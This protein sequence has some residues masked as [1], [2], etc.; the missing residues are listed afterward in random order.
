[1]KRIFLILI[2][3]F[4]WSWSQTSSTQRNFG[5]TSAP[6]PSVSSMASYVNTPVSLST[7]V[8]DISLPLFSLPTGN[9]NLNLSVSLNYHVYNSGPNKRG[10]EV[11]IGWSMIKG[12]VISKE[13]VN[14]PDEKYQDASKYDYKKNKFDD[15][16]YYNF[17]GN[18]GKFKIVRD[19]INNTFTVNNISG[20]NLKIEYTRDSNPA[21]LILNS[22]TI[23]DTKGF[24]YVFSDY[25]IAR[26]DVRYSSGFN[27]RS[28]FYL[29]KIVDE[30]NTEIANFTYEKKSKYVGYQSLVL[31]YQYCKLETI[32]TRYGKITFENVFD[33]DVETFDKNEDPYK[34]KTI[35]QWNKSSHLISK[36]SFDYWNSNLKYLI[37]LDK[38]LKEIEKRTFDYSSES[39]NNYGPLS[40]PNKYGD[41]VCTDTRPINPKYFVSALKSMTLP[42]GG[43]VE[44][45][46]EAGEI[47][48]NKVNSQFSDD[49]IGEPNHQYLKVVDSINFDTHTTR[50]YT[51]QVPKKK[52]YRVIFNA[53]E[54]Y[55]IKNMHGDIIIPPTYELFNSAGQ[56][57]V[58]Y[59]KRCP[60]IEN[61]D[62]P[63]GTYTIKISGNGNGSLTNYAVFNTDG[64]IRNSYYVKIPRIKSI[65]YY[66]ANKI[67]KKT[68]TYN[69]DLFTDS[70][71]SSGKMF[72][73]ETCTHGE[74]IDYD[75][76]YIIYTNVKEIYGEPSSNLGYT[77]HYFKTLDDYI[78]N[79]QSWYRP[80]YNMVSSGVKMK[81]ET[82]NKQNQLLSDENMDYVFD[83]INGVNEYMVCPGYK[84]KASWLKSSKTVSNTYYS[85]GTKLQNISESTFNPSNFQL[86][87]MKE[88]APDGKITEKK[89]QY[90]GDLNNT[91]LINANMI[92]VPLQTNVKVNGILVGKTETKYDAASSLHP[93]SVTSFNTQNQNQVTEGYME[94]YDDK[95]NL[96]Q[97]RGKDNV[98][99][100]T[101][102][103]YYQTY[104]IAKIEG[105][106]FNQVS[107]LQSVI[108]AV[109]AS[110]ADADNPDNEA[111]LLQAL[112]NMRKDPALKDY[113]MTTST[114]DPMIGVTNSISPNG[115]KTTYVY[116]AFNRLIKI[117]DG[118]GKTVSEYQY[119]YRH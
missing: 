112:E 48:A 80:Y 69:Y 32:S 72:Y 100:T 86:S 1:M 25:S 109:S 22:F 14:D 90:A 21:T 7:G 10:T 54:T 106:S 44:Y 62:L 28:A 8:P 3:L 118:N 47:Y 20:N 107:V 9:Q 2:L 92:S 78:L 76:R 49:Y 24:K 97:A 27:Y 71:S 19:T 98:P 4:N 6:V 42:E 43:Q 105:L 115:M 53:D 96:L 102:W 94:Q 84:S 5:D 119:N 70:N 16:Y 58:E 67:V 73:N 114:Y 12:G 88:T 110:N 81:M 23:T 37:K 40:D 116:D 52:M 56:K 50:N 29:T 111:V 13:N 26:F 101:I 61:Y 39:L 36:Y 18:S 11:G 74:D 87:T 68:I 41:Y 82:F 51:F 46:F 45:N 64:P 108:A 113:V 31:L 34:I 33:Q 93:S 15:I 95:G 79:N 30:S 85:N 55:V 83:E 89:I 59:Q 66:D 57:L 17:P 65:K 103:G 91:R 77:K 63:T 35:S 38:S 104:P 99:V 75:D 117:M 60:W